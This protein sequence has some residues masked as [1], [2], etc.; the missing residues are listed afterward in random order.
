MKRSFILITSI[1]IASLSIVLFSILYPQITAKAADSFGFVLLNHYARELDI[2]DSFYLTALTSDGKKPTWRSSDSSVVSVNTYGKV[3]AKK[4]GTA[5]VTVKI[6]NGEASCKILVN[7]TTIELNHEKLSLDNGSTVRLTA[8]VSTGAPVKWHSQKKS[9]ATVSED[10]VVTAKKPGET[11]ITATA[12]GTK[13]TCKVTVKQ[14]MVRLSQKRIKLYRL[15]TCQL[16]AS[17]TST[18]KP[19]WKSNRKSVAT[20]DAN[21]LVTAM[22]HG[23]ALITVTVDGVSKICEVVVEQPTITLSQDSLDMKTE[24]THAL[25][26]QVSSGNIPI[27]S[28]SNTSVATVDSRG[29]ITAH[30]PGR[31][32][33]YAKEDGVK[34]RCTVKVTE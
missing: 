9:V 22:K 20:V 19:V 17:A 14:P 27:W 32:Y 28:S 11:T 8:D 24:E 2:G 33:I 25:T 18:T 16:T 4:A 21:G 26:A 13:V 29:V 3:T 7:K 5:I 31:A 30:Q 15:G 1:M 10:G 34:T 23:S 12:D 6:K